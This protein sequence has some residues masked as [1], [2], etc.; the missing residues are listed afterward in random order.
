M[1]CAELCP[2]VAARGRDDWAL[3]DPS[4]KAIERPREIRE[5]VPMRIEALLRRR[6]WDRL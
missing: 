2:V 4:A 1:R 6:G 3:E 5:E